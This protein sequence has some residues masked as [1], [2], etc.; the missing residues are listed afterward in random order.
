MMQVFD[1][2][3]CQLGEGPLWH[4]QRKQLFWFDINCQRLYARSLDQRTA[5]CWQF[6][7]YVSAAAVIDEQHLLI[8]SE[9]A[10]LSFHLDN[11]QSSQLIS[12]EA[13]N[14]MT[15]SNDGRADP[16]GGFWVG[17]MAKNAE[18]Q[19]GAIYRFYRGE[20]RK[21]YSDLTIPNSLCFSPC[22][23]SAYFTD[24]ATAQIMK[25]SL[26]SDGWPREAAQVFIDMQAEK[27]A[28]DGAVVDAQGCLWNAQWGSG[29]V[30][31]YDTQ[32][33]FMAEFAAPAVHTTCPAFGG[34]DLNVLF[35]TSANQAAA[36]DDAKRN[37]QEGAD[38]AVFFQATDCVG[39]AE[40]NVDIQGVV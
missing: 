40:H 39:Q 11:Q 3:A 9:S 1:A 10:L 36:T 28:P 16:F 2:T 13:D 27:L 32:G 7:E 26:N 35:V 33:V 30:A 34:D 24:T 12:L 4:P 25:V 29:R 22:G 38:G 15:R 8:A 6:V 37:H 23:T 17:T 19:A 21:L 20:L 31:R 18:Y 14:P 5:Q